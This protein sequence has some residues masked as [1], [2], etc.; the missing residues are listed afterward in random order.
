VKLRWSQR[1]DEQLV[2]ACGRGDGAALGEIFDRHHQAVYRFLSRLAGPGDGSD[3]DDLVQDTFVRIAQ[4]AS[5]FAGRSTARS[6]IFAI[7][8]HAAV[9]HVRR[10][11]RRRDIHRHSAVER[12]EAPD[13]PDHR[14]EGR[15]AL[16]R[17]RRAI[18]ELPD[19]LRVTYVMCEL[20]DTPGKDAAA[21]LGVPEGTIWRRLHDARRA[22]RDTMDEAATPTK[23]AIND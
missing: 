2:D 15:E 22:L 14:T 6:W 8:S 10:E 11:A 23:E 3:L 4:G 12:A 7:A 5:G 9:D 1:S 21:A 18:E 20:E 16:G 13:R 19:D 17:L